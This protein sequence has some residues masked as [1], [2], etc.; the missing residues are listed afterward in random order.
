MT[1]LKIN[2]LPAISTLKKRCRRFVNL[3]TKWR[4]QQDRNTILPYAV[5]ILSRNDVRDVLAGEMAVDNAAMTSFETCFIT[6]AEEWRAM[7]SAQLRQ[8][9]RRSNAAAALIPFDVDIL[10]LAS[11]IFT[12]SRCQS[13][14][15]RA[16][17]NEKLPL[18]YPTVLKHKCLCECCSRCC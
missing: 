9:A 5:D 7:C 11:T 17:G 14:S 10:D 1:A 3:Y 15:Y 16:D 12:C 18:V 4:K 8:L 6:W 13:Q 2:G